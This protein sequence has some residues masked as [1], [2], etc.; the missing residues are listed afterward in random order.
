MSGTDYL[1]GLKE[2]LIPSEAGNLIYHFLKAFHRIES[3][4]ALSGM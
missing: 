3:T 1:T 4:R 2:K